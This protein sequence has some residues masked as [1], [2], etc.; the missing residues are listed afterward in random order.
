MLIVLKCKSVPS[1]ILIYSVISKWLVGMIAMT[2]EAKAAKVNLNACIEELH[3]IE[4]F[5]TALTV[6]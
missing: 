5:G 2:S 4:N 3:K 6:K 1:K